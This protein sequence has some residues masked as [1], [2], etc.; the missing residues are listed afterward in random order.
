[1]SSWHEIL[2]PEQLDEYYTR[3]ASLDPRFARKQRAFYEGRSEAQ[4]QVQMHQAWLCNEPTSYQLAR[5]HKAIKT[6]EREKRLAGTAGAA[7]RT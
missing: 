3:A 7:A 1:M 2:N 4:L 5:S 6:M